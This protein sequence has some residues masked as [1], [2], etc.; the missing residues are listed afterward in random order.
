[1]RKPLV[2]LSFI[3]VFYTVTLPM[4]FINGDAKS[5]VGAAGPVR[6]RIDDRA[7]GRVSGRISGVGSGGN[8]EYIEYK[9]PKIITS[10]SEIYRY[11][12]IDIIIEDPPRSDGLYVQVLRDGKA[13]RSGDGQTRIPFLPV[14]EGPERRGNEAVKL[15]AVYLP[16]WNERPGTYDIAVMYA[17]G[18]PYA[19]QVPFTIK[20]RPLPPV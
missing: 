9:S 3:F 6:E 5:R 4:L 15:R 1:M 17:N 7:S 10:K 12:P 18:E 11:E 8:V 14:S 2:G 19:P 20:K 13:R 16:D